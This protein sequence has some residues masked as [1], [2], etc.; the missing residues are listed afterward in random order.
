MGNCN[1]EEALNRVQ[2]PNV[3]A[4]RVLNNSDTTIDGNKQKVHSVEENGDLILGE[5]NR[6]SAESNQVMVN[7]TEATAEGLKTL[8]SSMDHVHNY[9][10]GYEEL[11]MDV[12]NNPERLREIAEELAT[13]DTI[14]PEHK[15]DLMN[16]LEDIID[17]AKK[18]LPAMSVAINKKANET[19]GY[20]NLSDDQSK[21]FIRITHKPGG[22]VKRSAL[23]TYVH[24]LSHAATEYALSTPMARLAPA[25][26]VL[27]EVREN[28]FSNVTVDELAKHMPDKTTAK[29]DAEELLQYL[30]SK[31]VSL[32]EFTAHA[33]THPAMIKALRKLKPPKI[34]KKKYT[35]LFNF[36]VDAIRM[37]LE[38]F[39]IKFS[40]APRDSEY[41]R[42]AWVIDRFAESN[43]KA[44]LKIKENVFTF[45]MKVLGIGDGF[46]SKKIND[47][48]EDVR[49]GVVKVQNS[50]SSFGK[51]W[52]LSKLVL[53][54]TVD[55]R[56]KDVLKIT[57]S[58]FGMK[59][60]G[61]LGGLIKDMMGSDKVTQLLERIG[62]NGNMIDQQRESIHSLLIAEIKESFGG[63]LTGDEK[64]AVEM[65][66]KTDFQSIADNE[67][68]EDL[69]S[70]DAYR[71]EVIEK[72]EKWLH[73]KFDPKIANF[74]IGQSRG[75]AKL[76]RT[77]R[78]SKHQ[79][80]SIEGIANL[81]TLPSGDLKDT[82][83]LTKSEQTALMEKLDGLTTLYGIEQYEPSV[84]AHLTTLMKE[85]PVAITT[86]TRWLRYIAL[87]DF[88]L[89]STLHAESSEDK[90][91]PMSPFA[92]LKGY[93][94][95]VMDM[96]TE[97]A[98]AP[99]KDEAKMLREG[100]KLVKEVEPPEGVSTGVKVGFYVSTLPL[101]PR[102]HKIGMRYTNPR[103]H[104][105]NIEPFYRPLDPVRKTAVLNEDMSTIGLNN[106]KELNKL[107]N[108]D[109]SVMETESDMIPVTNSNN[110]S[111]VTYKMALGEDFMNQN[112]RMERDPLELMG[113]TAGIIVDRESSMA[114]NRESMI[115]L[116]KE[117]MEKNYVPGKLL[118]KDN[119]EYIIVSPT[120]PDED[121]RNLWEVLPYYVKKEFSDFEFDN[122][123]KQWTP[124]FAIRRDL[125]LD[126]LG[127]H[128]KGTSHSKFIK[129]L[130]F[131]ISNGYKIASLVWK[132]IIKIEKAGIVLK[133][134]EVLLDN[135]IS[136]TIL[137][138]L[139]GGNIVKAVKYQVDGIKA[140]K[141]FTKASKVILSLEVKESTGTITP[142]ET[143][144]LNRTRDYIKNSP[145]RPLIDEGMYSQILEDLADNVDDKTV[146]NSIISDWYDKKL[147]KA[148]QLVKNGSDWV[149]LTVRNPIVKFMNT[150]TQYSD[151]VA[152]YAKYHMLMESKGASHEQAVEIVMDDFIN[153]NKANSK[154]LEWANKNG[155]V[156]F[157]KYFT[158]IQR[159]ISRLAKDKP[160]TVLMTVGLMDGLYGGLPDPTD[161]SIY[162]KDLLSITHLNP[163]SH[164]ENFLEPGLHK[165]GSNLLG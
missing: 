83:N 25:R 16:A 51:A 115:P 20:I 57:L 60:E 114:F 88:K 155:L 147:E 112:L 160:M 121:V 19:G 100:Y 45:I 9:L 104:H 80:S 142:D 117:Q 94:H 85:K 110:N 14:S 31:D 151:F 68:A 113:A 15:A 129:N 103:K 35:N 46:L 146:N 40:D 154:A 59:P 124:G 87:S 126:Y 11:A 5:G 32:S 58:A 119:K 64:N 30:S 10:N 158:R 123:T 50:K 98:Y 102:L 137:F 21:A 49:K 78:A 139:S 24:E 148:P 91:P 6:V 3:G 159:T 132:D 105:Q 37:V 107:L 95:T 53:K 47:M 89:E 92:R 52:E 79:I 48:E 39:A 163:F 67:K 63:K 7:G 109:F 27:Q 97:T 153:Y 164:I 93:R 54:A 120:A 13:L 72:V 140:L 133:V 145:I 84:R 130:P 17:P 75:L 22:S 86:T 150:A 149:L 44:N 152:R 26:R 1:I 162:R 74:Y 161:S 122:E 144:L 38:F 136:N 90:T 36:F 2:Q 165:F 12:V 42:M 56:Y 135:V 99:L 23:E 18:A 125:M 156:M 108:G 33:R 66:M 43:I 128:E 106:V 62:L 34:E 73:S 101:R 41:A 118:G 111:V 71:K 29:K 55:D 138:V 4:A 96:G 127:F 131:A 82:V 69:I 116:I 134:P 28:F 8:Y 76:M 65:L 157:S 70:N 61:L 141:D 143:R 81:A 77:G